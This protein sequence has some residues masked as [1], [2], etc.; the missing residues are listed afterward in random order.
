MS[1]YLNSKGFKRLEVV[2]RTFL[3]GKSPGG[4][5]KKALVAWRNT[6]VSNAEGGLGFEEFHQLSLVFKMRLCGKLMNEEEV[7]W[8]KLS[9]E[10]IARSL[11][12]GAGC[13]TRR[14]WMAAEGLLLDN[15]TI[16]GFPL[17]RDLARELYVGRNALVFDNEGVVLPIHLTIE[18]LLIIFCSEESLTPRGLLRAQGVNTLGH[19]WRENQSWRTIDS[20]HMATRRTRHRNNRGLI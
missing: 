1:M 19:F 6:V 2:C 12:G 11:D 16:H 13:K 15:I 8:V 14:R 4:H 9:Q 18:Q 3:W 7:L 17:L 20:F 5:Y 10:S